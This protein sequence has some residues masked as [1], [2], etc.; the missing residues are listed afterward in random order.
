MKHN[1]RI[2]TAALVPAL[3]LGGI[4]IGTAATAV[5]ATAGVAAAAQSGSWST[6][7][8]LTGATDGKSVI[9]V[10]TTTDGTA[11]AVWYRWPAGTLDAELNVAVRP[12]S[13][14][15]WGPA[16]VLSTTKDGMQSVRLTPA[17]DGSM[18]VTWVEDLGSTSVLRATSLAKGATAWPAP[19][20]IATRAAIGDMAFAHDAT[21]GKSVAVWRESTSSQGSVLYVSERTGAGAWSAPRVLGGASAYWPQVAIAPDGAVTAVWDEQTESGRTVMSVERPAGS[22]QW[23]APKP[24][25]APNEGGTP[26]LSIGQDGT[27]A[28]AW[29]K[30]IESPGSTTTAL[31]TAVRAAGGGSWTID[32]ARPMGDFAAVLDPLVGPT[33]E[34]TFVW[35]EDVAAGEDNVIGVR[36]AS[37]TPD[38]AWTAVKTLSTGYVPEQFDAAIGADGTVQVGW[39]QSGTTDDDRRFYT[40]ARINGTWTAPSQLSRAGSSY[41]EGRVAVAPDG[42]ATAV[43][44]QEDQLWAAGTGLTTPPAPAKHR[45]YVGKDGFPDLYAQTTAGALYVYQGNANH[46]LTTKVSG[47]T[48]PTTSYVVPFGDLNGDG[49][50][51]TLVRTAAGE[52]YRYNPACG[53]PV[54]PAAPNARI[55]SSGWAAFD[56]L[57]YSGDFNAD[58]RPDLIARQIST[59]DLYLYTGTTTGGLTRVGKIGSGWKSLTI[60]GTG[61]LNGDKNADLIARTSTGYLYRYLGTGRGTIGS[62][63]KIGS[64]WGGMVNMIG[65]GD[66]TGD[67]KN[68]IIGRTT[69]GDLY[70]YAG[71]GTGAIGSG[72][73][74]GTGWKSFASI[75]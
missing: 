4:G 19:S 27:A 39:A 24:V 26:Q 73:K 63:V 13:S 23:T 34:V 46:T 72:A 71:T 20:T 43:W 42:D 6:P 14:T 5:L 68:D 52:L 35:T 50:N 53:T 60:V 49:C 48:W 37:R 67:G 47:G 62:G 40:S 8:A 66:L 55:G 57:T 51:D 74:I 12:A 29:V 7:T 64:G 61:D 15:V 75:K 36:T 45:D 41:A 21:A 10:A 3:A 69:A 31:V 58:R 9:D 17:A 54:T 25:S 16:K 30:Y 28:L 11:V 70:R 18:T 65:I 2:V 44:A 33:G 1:R 56:A 38:G 59:G 22:T 32:A